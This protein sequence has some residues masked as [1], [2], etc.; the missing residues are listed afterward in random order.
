MKLNDQFPTFA[1]HSKPVPNGLI[2][3]GAGLPPYGGNLNTQHKTVS[4]NNWLEELAGLPGRILPRE[5]SLNGTDD[6]I[7]VLDN[8]SI[9][10]SD[11]YTIIVKTTPGA[12]QLAFSDILSKRSTVGIRM[13]L[14]GATKQLRISTAAGVSFDSIGFLT[15]GSSNHIAFTKSGTTGSIYLGGSF[16]NSGTV[17]ADTSNLADLII[18]NFSA[19]NYKGNIVCVAY[20]N[21][22]LTPQ[23][24]SDLSSGISI[25]ETSLGA[26]YYP[27]GQGDYEYDVSENGN[28]GTWSG[29][30]PRF[31]YDIEGSLYPL[32]NG[33]SM[34]SNVAKELIRVPYDING[35]PLIAPPVP[36]GYTHRSEHSESIGNF[37][38]FDCLVDFANGGNAQ[39]LIGTLHNSPSFSYDSFNFAN[40]N[41]IASD[42][43]GSF[44]SALLNGID[45]VV[46]DTFLLTYD[47]FTL[48]SGDVPLML[49]QNQLN[50][51]GSSKSNRV[52][53]P[54]L[55]NSWVF[56]ITE[57]GT[58]YFEIG[59]RNIATD[60]NFQNLSLKKIPSTLD[61]F[62]RGNT[63]IFNENA[64]AGSDYDSDNTYQFQID[65]LD[66][67]ILFTWRNVGYKGMLYAK[68]YLDANLNIIWMFEMLNYLSDH[69]DEEEYRIMIYC[70]YEPIIMVDEGG[71]Y[72]ID[73][74][75]Y[76]LI[77]GL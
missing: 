48:N 29:T 18:G 39:E 4:G 7:T 30:G 21:R 74:D 76:V 3:E 37:N 61:N 49:F 46:G 68:I 8:A 12:T 38:M 71:V 10:L 67:R 55:S 15:Y 43:G 42:A 31:D 1:A 44:W 47:S 14:V 17:T 59:D 56:T 11:N 52:D 13:I 27:T 45:T 72:L 22:V 34:Y 2:P 53:D 36:V 50:G 60:F 35:L 62:N 65:N 51:I 64:R 54:R 16:D 24:I 25:S 69:V 32:K 70:G 20:Y 66:P 9:P 33:L 5:A 28:H 40:N 75:D 57:T 26:L 77:E 63:I 19:T 23:E 58:W 6:D 73:G 41:M